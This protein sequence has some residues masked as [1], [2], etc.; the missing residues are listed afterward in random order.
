MSGMVLL[1][2]ILQPVVADS[3]TGPLSN[4]LGWHLVSAK[5]IEVLKDDTRYAQSKNW[6]LFITTALSSE[7][8]ELVGET[9]TQGVWSIQR[10]DFSIQVLSLA[11]QSNCKIWS[12]EFNTSI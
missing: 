3:P 10:Q 1:T 11:K 12:K 8:P 6:I 2:S 5:G 9:T 4:P 7:H